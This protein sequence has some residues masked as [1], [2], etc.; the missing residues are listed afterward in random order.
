MRNNKRE[1]MNLKQ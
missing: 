1:I